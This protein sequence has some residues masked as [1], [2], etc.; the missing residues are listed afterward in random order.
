MEILLILL[1]IYRGFKPMRYLLL[2]VFISTFA[3][4]AMAQEERTANISKNEDP[5]QYLKLFGDVYERVKAL[6]VDELTEQEIIEHAITGMLTGLDPH[7]SYLDNSSFDDMKVQTRGSFGGLGI[8]VTME[9]GL[10]KVVSPIDDTPAFEAG[11]EAGDL[12]THLDGKPVVGLQL[13]DAVDKMRGKVGTTIELTIRREGTAEPLKIKIKRDI[14]KIRSVRSRVEGDVGYIRITTFNQQTTPGV[15]KAIKDIKAELGD[16][17][18]GYV[19]DLRNN[20]GGLL[21]EAIGVSDAFLDKGEIVSTR[22]RQEDDTRR[23]NATKGDLADELPLV[24]LING[25]SASASE[26]VAGSLQDHRRAV[27]MGTPSFGKG[28]VQTIIPL[29]KDNAMRLTT[30]R[31]YTPSGRSIQAKGIVPDI[32]VELAKLENIEGAEG[33][34]E[35]DLVGALSNATPEGL[36]DEDVPKIELSDKAKADY[37]LLRAIDLLRGVALYN[38]SHPIEI[39]KTDTDATNSDN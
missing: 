30:A 18:L 38:S 33:I 9:N 32:L 25:G 22:G 17:L 3:M 31:Y 20:P 10:V 16:K 23:D 19:I 36:D 4:S 15:E 28:S 12:I 1:N 13:S 39:T 6:Y 2:L 21:T 11:V 7:S 27:V 8:E 37:Q 14:I 24:V 29:P 34:K 35:S 26:I 5:Y